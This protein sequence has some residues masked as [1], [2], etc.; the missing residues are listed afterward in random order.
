MTTRPLDSPERCRLLLTVADQTFD[1]QHD[2]FSAL[3]T[4][5]GNYV[6]L[7][8]VGIAVTL[9]ILPRDLYARLVAAPIGVAILTFLLAAISIVAGLITIGCAYFALRTEYI[10]LRETKVDKV[11]N[12][13]NNPAPDFEERMAKRMLEGAEALCESNR[14]KARFLHATEIALGVLLPA[15]VALG[16]VLVLILPE[17]HQ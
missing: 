8:S 10:P 11:I 3:E 13:F 7:G 12:T 2:W 6:T 15:L 17:V 1:Q 16:V 5:A 9:A 4:K 14:R